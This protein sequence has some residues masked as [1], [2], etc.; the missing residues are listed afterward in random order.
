MKTAPVVVIAMDAFKGCIGSLDAAAVVADG[1]RSVWPEIVVCCLPVADGGEGTIDAIHH[2]L[3]GEWIPVE[4]TGPMGATVSSKYLR[5]PDGTAILELAAASGLPLVPE[6]E[7]NPLLATTYGTGE[8]IRHV[9]DTGC[10]RLMLGVGGSAT[11]DGGVGLLEALGARFYDA[12]GALV[13]FGPLKGNG[14]VEGVVNGGGSLH[15]IARID[16]TGLH[17]AFRTNHPEVPLTV[18]CDVSNPLCGPTGASA[19]FGP[20]KGATPDMVRLLDAHL[21][22]YASVVT[23]QTGMEVETLPGS[24]AAG[25][26]NASLVPFC[27][28]VLRPGVQWVLEAVGLEAVLG[29]ACLVVTGEGRMDGQSVYGKAPVG[30]AGMAKNHTLPVVAIVGD[31]G[32]NVEAVYEH[33]VDRILKLRTATMTVSESMGLVR[34]RLFDAGVRIARDCFPD[35]VLCAVSRDTEGPQEA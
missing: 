6:A 29:D 30:V 13:R 5:L 1:I 24:G 8:L 22:Q 35:G 21:K 16:T 18:A 20:Q 14:G 2:G 11:N 27:H 34:E 7:R 31:T 28:A 10:T 23:A 9:L 19:T 15:R 33:G 32:A 4:V 3:G 12:S 25:G 26:V 17:P